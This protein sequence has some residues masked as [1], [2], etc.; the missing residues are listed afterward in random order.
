MA[1]GLQDYYKSIVVKAIDNFISLLNEDYMKLI[2]LVSEK[3]S[4]SE[5]KYWEVEGSFKEP[6]MDLLM[7]VSP[8][9][10]FNIL[11]KTDKLLAHSSAATSASTSSSLTGYD[12]DCYDDRDN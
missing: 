5:I 1:T 9:E 8:D 2:V 12:C 4:A 3:F 11:F 10:F 7:E 6:F